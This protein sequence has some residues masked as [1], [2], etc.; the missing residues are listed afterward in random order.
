MKIQPAS[1]VP[2]TSKY[3]GHLCNG[4]S[5]QV[6]DRKLFQPLPAAIE[7]I[8]CV[9][10]KYPE[11]FRWN[12]EHFDRLAGSGQ[13]RLAIEQGQTTEEILQAWRPALR[14]FDVHRKEHL[15]YR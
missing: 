6:V 5:L 15:L 7:L 4:I 13:L 9:R 8:R 12:S 10:Q 14:E 11:Q 1:F 2:K 3:A